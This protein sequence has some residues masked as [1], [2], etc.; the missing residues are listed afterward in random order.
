MSRPIRHPGGWPK[1]S[2]FDVFDG[3]G[4]VV[5]R[6]ISADQVVASYLTSLT[7]EQVASTVANFS[8]VDSDGYRCAGHMSIVGGT[9]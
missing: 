7:A 3:A 1:T 9:L 6:N 2:R 4:A 5:V 8:Y